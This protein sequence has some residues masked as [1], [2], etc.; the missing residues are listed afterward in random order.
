MKNL[1]ATL[2]IIIISF[3]GST[4]QAQITFKKESNK[5][6]LQFLDDK[7]VEY[8]KEDIATLHDLNIFIDYYSKEML[9][10]PEAYFFNKQGFRVSKKYKGNSCGKVIKNADKINKA[11]FDSNESVGDW[12]KYYSFPFT[13]EN[14]DSE[15]DAYVIITWGVFAEINDS[16][17]T[18]FNW[19][20]SLKNNKDLNIKVILLNLDIQDTWQI[21]EDNAKV[22]GLN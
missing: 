13:T 18:A 9:S 10:I 19:Y 16:N 21:S 14:N 7:N 20:Q 1:I 11:D 5:S 3:T 2:F 15:Y 4:L 17:E 12:L 22:L 8:S 6:M